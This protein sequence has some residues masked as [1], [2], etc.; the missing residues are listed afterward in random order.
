MPQVHRSVIDEDEVDTV[1]DSHIVF[2]GTI[3]TSKSLLIKGTV[4]G[5]IDCADDLFISPEG[6]VDAEIHTVRLTVRGTLDGSAYA[7]ESIEVL[8][9]SHVKASL[10]AP[11]IDIENK[12][13]FEGSATITGQ[14]GD[15]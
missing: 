4:R 10:Q 9:G 13:G 5:L 7:S 1:L 12:E 3:R 8:A 15:A 2:S 11:E 14:A 6:I